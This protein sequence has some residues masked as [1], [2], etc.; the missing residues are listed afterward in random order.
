LQD[1]DGEISS[2]SAAAAIYE[3]FNL[4]L[5]NLILKD[6][7]GDLA[8]RYVGKG[9][10]PVLAEISAFSQRAREW[11]QAILERPESHWFDLGHGETRDEVVRIALRETVDYLKEELGP[12]VEDWAWGK[13]HRLVF[14]HPLG[15]GP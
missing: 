11:L 12:Q 8:I 5:M 10:T 15:P 6:K 9:P 2:G 1:W 3:V 7:L 14:P 4:R 13:L